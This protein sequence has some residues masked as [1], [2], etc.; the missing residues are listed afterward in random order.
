MLTERERGMLAK[1]FGY[2]GPPF[3]GLP[4][5]VDLVKQWISEYP[6]SFDVSDLWQEFLSGRPDVAMVVGEVLGEIERARQ[7][8]IRAD[9][10]R[11]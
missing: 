1:H 2:I 9:W 8:P 10:G 5:D 6:D 4:S 7:S 11:S 3:A